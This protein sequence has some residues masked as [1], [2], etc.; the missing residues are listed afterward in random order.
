MQYARGLKR[1]KADT[2]VGMYVN[3]RTLDY[4]EDG[5]AAVRLLLKRGFEAGV[6]PHEVSV[7]FVD[8]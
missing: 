1:D 8:D 2:F 6:I 3:K 7:E 4:G 5:K